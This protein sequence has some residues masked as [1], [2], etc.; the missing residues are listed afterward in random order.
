MNTEFQEP[1][2]GDYIIEDK[3][4]GGYSVS[5][6][7]EKFLDEFDDFDSAFNFVKDRME[8]KQF[9]PN[10]WFMNERGNLDLLDKNGNFVESNNRSEDMKQKV[11]AFVNSIAEDEYG[12]AFDQLKDITADA[13][14]SDIARRGKKY[15]DALEDE[16]EDE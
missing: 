11:E 12:D 15:M 6:K 4:W 14:S 16:N 8:Q 7:N 5:Q 9:W 10:V 2:S 3:P 1:E 13:A